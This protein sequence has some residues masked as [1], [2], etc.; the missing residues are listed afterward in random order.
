MKVF[1]IKKTHLLITVGIL[2]FTLA[3]ALTGVG[4]DSGAAYFCASTRK[5]PIYSVQTTENKVSISFDAAWGADKTHEIMNVCDAYKVKATFF[6]VGFWV[7]KYPD[8]VKEIYKRGFEIGIHSNTHPDM[9]SLTAAQIKEELETNI[10]LVENLTGFR[11]KLFRPPYGY[12]N[13]TLIE[14]C[15]SLN[16]SCIEWSVVSLDG[17]GLSAS[18]LAGRV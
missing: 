9:T 2:V 17:K 6:L 11:P 18:E 14:F 15:K 7:E 8:M 1:F 16:L 5:L 10:K 4:V 12:Y 13:D 3:F